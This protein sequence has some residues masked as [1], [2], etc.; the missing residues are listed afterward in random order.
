MYRLSINHIEKLITV[1]ISGHMSKEE[2]KAFAD[3][4]NTLIP[5]LDSTEYCI[6]ANF[7]RMDPVSQDSI[8]YLIE[9]FKNSLLNVRKIAAVHK[10]TVTQMQMRKI[11]EQAKIGN[12]IDNRIMRFSS[13]AEAMNYLKS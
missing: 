11:E 8:P 4:V 9:V 7:E 13:K 5:R 3:E 12:S 2:V 6:Y 1:E 10:R